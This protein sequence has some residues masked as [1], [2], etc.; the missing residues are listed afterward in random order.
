MGPECALPAQSLNPECSPLEPMQRPCASPVPW[1]FP[2]GMCCPVGNTAAA[3]VLPAVSQGSLKCVGPSHFNQQMEKRGRGAALKVQHF[4]AAILESLSGEDEGR[5]RVCSELQQCC[6][7]H[8][9]SFAQAVL[10]HPSFREGSRAVQQRSLRSPRS[11][12]AAGEAVTGLVALTRWLWRLSPACTL[13]P[14]AL[15]R[16]QESRVPARYSH[17][18]A[19]GKGH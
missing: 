9:C 5:G 7:G 11:V 14:P 6:R 17:Y 8:P 3:Q 15:W 10:S 18:G 19:S 2:A 4:T 12:S 16:A 1:P 13:T